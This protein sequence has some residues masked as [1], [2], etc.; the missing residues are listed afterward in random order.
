MGEAATKLPVKTEEKSAGRASNL[1]VLRPFESLR[2]EI[3]RLF[4][5][6]GLGFF[7]GPSARSLFDEPLFRRGEPLFEAPAV[8][9]AEKE[10]EYEITTELPGMEES[11][12]EAGFR[13]G[14]LTLE[15]PKTQ[16]AQKS[17]KTIPIKAK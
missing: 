2:R 10:K 3:D 9:V 7:R 8:D 13:K 16:E 12:I 15:L 1:T 14:V 4:D 11:D 17:T 6:V 5:D